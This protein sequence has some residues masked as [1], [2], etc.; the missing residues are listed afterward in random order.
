MLLRVYVD[1]PEEFDRWVAHATEQLAENNPA[2]GRR[3]KG[4]RANSLHQLPCGKRHGRQM[5]DSDRT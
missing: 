4:F 1:T 3:A 5:G 2:V